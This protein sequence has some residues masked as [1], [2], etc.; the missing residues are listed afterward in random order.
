MGIRTAAAGL[1]IAR[2]SKTAE[3][4]RLGFHAGPSFCLISP[5]SRAAWCWAGREKP[6]I[7]PLE[8]T[9]NALAGA[10][11]GLA[12]ASMNTQRLRPSG[13][14][15]EPR[16]EG[17][18][19][20]P[21]V[22]AHTGKAGTHRQGRHTAAPLPAWVHPLGSG[23]GQREP[24]LARPPPLLSREKDGMNCPLS[25]AGFGL[26]GLLARGFPRPSPSSPPFCFP[27][28][29]FHVEPGQFGEPRGATFLWVPSGSRAQP[30]GLTHTHAHTHRGAQTH[31]YTGTEQPAP[32]LLQI[33]RSGHCLHPRGSHTHST[34]TPGCAGPLLGRTPPSP[35]PRHTQSPPPPPTVAG[36]ASS[37][38][39]G[40]PVPARASARTARGQS[41]QPGSAASSP[42]ASAFLPLLPGE[43]KNIPSNLSPRQ[44]SLL[45][46][47]SCRP[48]TPLGLPR[49]F[50]SPRP[51]C[52]RGTPRS[53]RST[54][55]SA[56]SPECIPHV[57]SIKDFCH[58]VLRLTDFRC[59]GCGLRK[60]D[61]LLQENRGE[62]ECGNP[63]FLLSVI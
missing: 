12:P 13:P 8:R 38:P 58:A 25:D 31:R 46:R 52:L 4:A 49:A 57:V 37:L 14:P 53:A 63:F 24:S 16:A 61:L 45:A 5:P 56:V 34:S 44:G 6:G 18:A 7:P 35:T 39:P 21:S 47:R 27:G 15:G 10:P 20:V 11:R 43:R 9:I 54:A 22:P 1:G 26:G 33:E 62:G 30:Q 60:G 2:L 23:G 36:G 29:H 28:G 40:P 48:L 55:G 17:D 50:A 3:S 59:F 41:L 32:P 19:P 51:R 42:S